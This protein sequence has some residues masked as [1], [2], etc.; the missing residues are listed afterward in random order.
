MRKRM[1]PLFAP[2]L[3]LAAGAG[4]ARAQEAPVPIS[5]SGAVT[6]AADTAPAVRLAELRTAEAEARVRQ[7]RGGLLPSVSAAAGAATQTR[8]RAAFG[9]E[10]PS[11]P[12]V[13]STGDKIGPFETYD[14][15]L[16]AAAPVLDPAGLVRVRAQRQLAE[17][18]RGDRDAAAEAA[19]QRAA[20]AYLRAARAGATVA[21]RREDVR[22]AAELVDLARRQ[23]DAGVAA[24]ID[25]TRAQTQLVAARGALAVAEN[26]RAQADVELARAL[27]VDPST[28]FAVADTLSPAL[29]QPSVQ[30]EG[31]AALAAALANR[32]ELRAETARGEAARL[33]ARAVRAER[34][35]R[36]EVTAD[37]G[38]TGVDPSDAFPT[39]S[40]GL[41]VSLPVFDG[42]RRVART[43]EQELVARE[44]GVRAG[45]L[46]E[47]VAGEVR[48]ALLDVAS[49]QE[50]QRIAAERLQ[51]A[52]EELSQAQERFAN[53][54]A[55]NIEVIN[56]QGS[57]VR[58]RDAVIEAQ[59]ATAAA[60]VGLA[61]ATGTARAVR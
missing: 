34:L 36:L 55:G 20:V 33:S 7:A 15:R 12:G 9:I 39:Y 57:L 53:G 56:A 61:R 27:G 54:I 46:R 49:G 30:A 17:S 31:E 28:R 35:P 29:A 2:V 60:R 52:L 45:D 21:A 40:V 48:S 50:Q 8:N 51:L 25:V 14:A 43:E 59:F 4:A 11:I 37:Y 42:N 58:A 24:G 13:P 6:L 18:T 22:L 32:P 16:R 38:L 1:V 23:L 19:G 26:G 5:L 47:Q 10:F 3:A 41:Q 44:A